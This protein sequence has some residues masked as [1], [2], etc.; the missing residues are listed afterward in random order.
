MLSD[1]AAD[2]AVRGLPAL[3]VKSWADLNET[4]L[5]TAFARIHAAEYDLSLLCRDYWRRALFRVASND[6]PFCLSGLVF[7][8]QRLDNR[9]GLEIVLH[10][11]AICNRFFV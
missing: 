9:R 2:Q 3:I 11:D 8:Y 7:L 6:N 5:R 10:Y 4:M 1:W